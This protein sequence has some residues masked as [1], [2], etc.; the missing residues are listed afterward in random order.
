M[1]SGSAAREWLR[2][3]PY[4]RWPAHLEGKVCSVFDMTGL[5]AKNGAVYS[6]VRIGRAAAR[7]AR[8]A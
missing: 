6:H 3:A 4:W 2:W 1:V 5:C 7:W 8:R